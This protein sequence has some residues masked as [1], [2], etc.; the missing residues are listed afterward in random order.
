MMRRVDDILLF[1]LVSSTR[2]YLLTFQDVSMIYYL[3]SSVSSTRLY[4]LTSQDVSMI[5]CLFLSVSSTRLYSLTCCLV[6][7]LTYSNHLIHPDV[8][9]F[10]RDAIDELEVEA[11][12]Y[13]CDI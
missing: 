5:Y 9:V 2:L 7:L 12:T 13:S 4:L 6:D 8:V 10:G 11:Y 1:A 3:F